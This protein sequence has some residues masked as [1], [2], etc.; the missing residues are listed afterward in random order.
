M[1]T[2]LTHAYRFTRI[3]FCA[4]AL[5]CLAGCGESAD[6][7]GSLAARDDGSQPATDT[8]ATET[9]TG[10]APRER[11]ISPRQRPAGDDKSEPQTQLIRTLAEALDEVDTDDE[12][13]D[14]DDLRSILHEA[15]REL[16]H[17]LGGKSKEAILRANRK[18]PS[19]YR[20]EPRKPAVRPEKDDAT[21][22]GDAATEK[23][24]EEAP[25]P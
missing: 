18:P 13:V 14:K 3:L 4:T 1:Q 8:G 25:A 15:D 21:E 24:S 11:S 16:R 17:V 10:A 2:H 9:P 23:T 12:D 22:E 19:R 7:A 6:D 5:M 20:D